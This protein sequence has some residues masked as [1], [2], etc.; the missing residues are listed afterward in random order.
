[1]KEKL[2]FSGHAS[3]KMNNKQAGASLHQQK[4]EFMDQHPTSNDNCM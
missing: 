4:P 1:M 3:K 2:G